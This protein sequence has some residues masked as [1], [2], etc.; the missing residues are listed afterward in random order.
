MDISITL[1]IHSTTEGYLGYFHLAAIV[2][3]ASMNIGAQLF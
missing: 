2:N 1:F 3:R